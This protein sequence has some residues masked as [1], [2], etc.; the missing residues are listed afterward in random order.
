MRREMLR[1]QHER[2]AQM[3]HAKLRGQML[4]LMQDVGLIKNALGIRAGANPPENL[5]K[6]STDR[7]SPF[8]EEMQK[9]SA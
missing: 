2:E 7:V 3:A 6:T 4:T 8:L 1:A 9:F 5:A